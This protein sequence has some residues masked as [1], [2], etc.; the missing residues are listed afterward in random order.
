[1]ANV[2]ESLADAILDPV[3]EHLEVLLEKFGVTKMLEKANKLGDFLGEVN[4]TLD[5]DIKGALRDVGILNLQFKQSVLDPFM[6][7]EPPHK[8]RERVNEQLT[9]E[10]ETDIND[11]DGNNQ[12]LNRAIREITATVINALR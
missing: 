5:S 10:Q 9:V 3:V 8:I 6:R 1:M 11:Q 2:G 4:F 12:I 7:D